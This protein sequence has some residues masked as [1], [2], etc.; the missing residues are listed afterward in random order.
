VLEQLE[1]Q[2][3]QEAL[4][5]FVEQDFIAAGFSAAAIATEQFAIIQ[6]D[7]A[8]HSVAL[9]VSVYCIR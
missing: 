5:K 7:E 6:A 4:A 8:A 1:S 3:Y 2:F 9:R